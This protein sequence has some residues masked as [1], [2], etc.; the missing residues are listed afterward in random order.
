MTNINC[1]LL[2]RNQFFLQQFF[3][4]FNN[5]H[6]FPFNINYDNKEKKDK[7]SFTLM[8]SSSSFSV[9][10]YSYP[11]YHHYA[12]RRFEIQPKYCSMTC[13]K[14]EEEVLFS[15]LTSRLVF[16][17]G[18]AFCGAPPATFA[19]EKPPTRIRNRIVPPICLE[20]RTYGPDNYLN[21]TFIGC[22]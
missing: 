7:F 4:I 19:L 20:I 15:F 14:L 5:F 11:F 16:A 12:R 2:S 13:L 3:I 21:K 6:N 1:V 10:V 8:S 9:D 18:Q 22:H 17:I